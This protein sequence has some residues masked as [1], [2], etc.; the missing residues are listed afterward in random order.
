MII[1]IL[2][3]QI[4]I[5]LAMLNPKLKDVFKITEKAYNTIIQIKSQNNIPDEDFVRIMS[6][7]G[8]CAGTKYDLGFDQAVSDDDKTVECGD[9][10]LV[11]DNRC[12]YDLQGVTLEYQ[13]NEFG[14]GFVFDSPSNATSCGGCSGC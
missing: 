6:L 9:L 2:A 3:T 12:L 4:K 5:D 8:G 10:N 14:S 1:P 7:S 11:I 13:D